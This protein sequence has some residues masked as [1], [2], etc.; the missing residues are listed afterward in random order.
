MGAVGLST[1]L[2]KVGVEPKQQTILCGLQLLYL[3]VQ[4]AV[5]PPERRHVG[6]QIRQVEEE[7]SRRAG[8]CSF[9]IRIG[10]DIHCFVVEAAHR[11]LTPR[12]RDSS[13]QY[14]QGLDEAWMT[15]FRPLVFVHPRDRAKAPVTEGLPEVSRLHSLE[16]GGQDFLEEAFLVPKDEAVACLTPADDVVVAG[17]VDQAGR[18]R[19]LE[20]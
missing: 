12:P 13:H 3:L 2:I 8:L 4:L 18:A 1:G 20:C 11:R 10:I 15:P 7:R 16:V 5:L 19:R 9:V 6:S 14:W 17:I